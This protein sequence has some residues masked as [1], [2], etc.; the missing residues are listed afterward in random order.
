[1]KRSWRKSVPVSDGAFWSQRPPAQPIFTT[2][3]R[4][5]LLRHEPA[6]AAWRRSLRQR[7]ELTAAGGSQSPVGTDMMKDADAYRG[8]D[9][10]QG[11][12]YGWDSSGPM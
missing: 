5:F 7:A 11:T 4:R 9:T 10:Y 12:Y 8:G 1:M 6:P 2:A 3:C